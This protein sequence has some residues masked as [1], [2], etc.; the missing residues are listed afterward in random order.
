MATILAP[1]PSETKRS[2]SLLVRESKYPPQLQS[3]EAQKLLNLTE[4]IWQHLTGTQRLLESLEKSTAIDQPLLES[5]ED[6]REISYRPVPPNRSFTVR[7]RYN[8]KGRG[9]P[10][11]YPLDDE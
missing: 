1:R 8:F 11:P 9:E 7:V 2:P 4:A 6:S 10:L 5:A 3:Q